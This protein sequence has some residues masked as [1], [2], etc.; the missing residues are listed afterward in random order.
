MTERRADDASRDVTQWLK[1]FYM[2][3]KVGEEFAGTISGVASFVCSSRSTASTSMVSCT[4]PSSAAITS[5][6]TRRGTR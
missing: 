5:T 3:D 2:Q 4:S 1:C 6:T